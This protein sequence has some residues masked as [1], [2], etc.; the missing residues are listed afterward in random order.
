[1]TEVSL[2][3][4]DVDFNILFNMLDE[5]VDVPQNV[6]VSTDGNV[7]DHT[8]KALSELRHMKK[9]QDLPARERNILFLATI[10]HD[11]GKKYTSKH[12]STMRLYP[13]W[14]E[15][16]S[17][18]AREFLYKHGKLDFTT[19]EQIVDLIRFHQLPIWVSGDKDAEYKLIKSSLHVSPK[20]LSIIAEAEIRAKKLDVFL[21][22]IDQFEELAKKLNCYN[23]PY[24]FESNFNKYKYMERYKNY[25]TF[26]HTLPYLTD[27]VI[28]NTQFGVTI[29]CGLPGMGQEKWLK[30]NVECKNVISLDDLREELFNDSVLSY[31]TFMTMEAQS[32]ARQ[33][34]RQEIPFVWNAPNISIRAR[35]AIV[36]ICTEYEAKV[37][38]VYIEKPY[39]QW[40]Q[41]NSD[42]KTNEA[43]FN[44]LLSKIEVPGLEEACTV[45]YV[46]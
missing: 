6:R 5:L 26:G 35:D 8:M 24:E 4:E 28:D 21:K 40:K 27:T 22:Q 19:R 7:F 41:D 45:L 18:I 30:D 31:Q 11:M 3:K 46:V 42:G 34:L 43:I 2:T 20:L 44:K 10:M 12:I 13:D 37:S 17:I 36:K 32:K 38:I 15:I 25:I 14:A 9:W 29:V 23:M 16:S 39:D 33:L 1:M